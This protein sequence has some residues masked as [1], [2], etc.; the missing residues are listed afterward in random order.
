LYDSE[1]KAA[2][3]F[4]HSR[5]WYVIYDEPTGT[6]LRLLHNGELLSQCDVAQMGKADPASPTTLESFRGD[7]KKGLGDHFGKIISEQ[8]G[9]T[10]KGYREL[11]I[12]VGNNSEE[13]P[14]VWIYYL[15]TK[16]NGDQTVIAYVV[17]SD[18]LE[19]FGD[20]DREIVDSF[21]MK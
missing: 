4:L 5:N 1:D 12:V 9:K 15:L 2:W 20:A 16:P 14:L 10:K 21:E 7:L 8:E 19:K 3:K 6:K 11:K 18:N 17:Q 13:M